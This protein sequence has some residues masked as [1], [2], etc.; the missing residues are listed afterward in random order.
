MVSDNNMTTSGTSSGE[1]DYANDNIPLSL[2]DDPGMYSDNHSNPYSDGEGSVQ[3]PSRKESS[4]HTRIQRTL[5][6][7]ADDCLAQSLLMFLYADLRLLSATGRINTKFD[8]LSI[9]SDF[10]MKTTSNEVAQ[11]PGASRVI[12]L[13]I[14]PAQIMAVLIV[15]LRREV[16]SQ[17]KTLAQANGEDAETK[18][19]MEGLLTTIT[20]SKWRRQHED[21]MHVMLRAYN[22]MI[23]N[24]LKEKLPELRLDSPTMY[25]SFAETLRQ[26]RRAAQQA[27]QAAADAADELVH[28]PEKQWKK[29]YETFRESMRGRRNFQGSGGANAEGRLESTA[30]APDEDGE[31]H[32]EHS[33]AGST[34][35]KKKAS[36]GSVTSKKGKKP[37]KKVRLPPENEETK[38][39][40]Q[41]VHQDQEPGYITPSPSMEVESEDGSK[42]APDD[43]SVASLSVADVRRMRR[44]ASTGTFSGTASNPGSSLPSGSMSTSNMPSITKDNAPGT[45]SQNKAY[46]RGS[47]MSRLEKQRERHAL[48]RNLQNPRE[49]MDTFMEVEE[50]GNTFFNMMKEGGGSFR[51]MAGKTL[52]E[53]ELLD[54]MAQA[55][56]SRE[57]G[58]LDFLKDFFKDGSSSQVMIKS[59]ARIVW[60]ND[61]YPIKDCIYAIAVD[62]AKRRVFVVFRGAITKADWGHSYDAAF[63][64][65]ANPVKESYRKRT[66][67]IRMH[68]GFYRY[69]F[70]QRKDTGTS[71]YDEICNKVQEY[72]SS[73]IGEDYSL[74]INGFS[75]GAALSTVFGFYASTDERFT[76]YGPVKVFTFGCP[77]VAG[78]EFSRA[79][80]HQESKQKLQLARF[81]NNRDFGKFNF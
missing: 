32:D 38:E 42:D 74:V 46:R 7:E 8:V 59:Q 44:R 73:L 71:K 61:W 53:T 18:E 58:K 34:S 35:D 36:T 75:L 24:D 77:Y 55:I 43:G 11:L 23:G 26:R 20:D 54:H 62:K 63:K 17:K 16:L 22:D 49:E 33:T 81:H 79:F 41:E 72:G 48:N 69:L 12:D 2:S 29:R 39:P 14:S 4:T 13:G 40:E 28:S 52:T 21:D 25:R 30:E 64:R 68:R 65:V 66:D 27:A 3:P 6:E 80:R 56:E 76:Q 47:M 9:D 51:S 45:P 70:R 19:E 5:F 67:H 37:T 15:E 78:H 50:V 1:T 10:A 57:Y 60:L 31:S